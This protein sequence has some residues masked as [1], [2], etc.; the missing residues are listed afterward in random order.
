MLTGASLGVVGA[1]AAGPRPLFQL[2][3]TCGETWN[4]STY[5][6]HDDY[7]IDMTSTAGNNWGRPILAAYG[8]RVERSGIS[9]TLGGRTPAGRWGPAAAT[10]SRLTTVTAGRP[11]TCTWWS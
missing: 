2:P 5:V 6:G 11:S 8:G 4:L 1:Q 7:D 3:V 10:T 9:G